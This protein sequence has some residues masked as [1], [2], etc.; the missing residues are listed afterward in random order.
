MTVISKRL[1]GG[2]GGLL[3]AACRPTAQPAMNAV[4]ALILRLGGGAGGADKI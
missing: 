1:K 2:G 4:A 3:G